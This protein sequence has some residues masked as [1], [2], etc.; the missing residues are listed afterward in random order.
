MDEKEQLLYDFENG[1]TVVALIDRLSKL[2]QDLIVVND[3]KNKEPISDITVTDV[4]YCFDE[5]ITKK[6]V[7]IY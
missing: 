7:S 4:D 3:C 1:I 5:I 6:V 2:P